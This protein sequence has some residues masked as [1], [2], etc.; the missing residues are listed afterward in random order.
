MLNP[1]PKFRNFKSRRTDYHMVIMFFDGSQIFR[2]VVL[3]Q[4]SRILRDGNSP[5][6]C[7]GTRRYLTG[8]G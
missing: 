3:I 2:L 5:T 7:F 4:F 1:K 6:L 8:D